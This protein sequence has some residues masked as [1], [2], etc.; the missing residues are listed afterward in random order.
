MTAVLQ[1]KGGVEKKRQSATKA[2]SKLTNVSDT[3]KLLNQLANG[4]SNARR[5]AGEAM[6]IDIRRNRCHG[7][8]PPRT[9]QQICECFVELI[10]RR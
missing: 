1:A 10:L 6:S 3:T 4:S 8:L 7:W 2:F 9:D 5:L